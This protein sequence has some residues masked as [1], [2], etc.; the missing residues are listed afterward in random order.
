MSKEQIEGLFFLIHCRPL[1]PDPKTLPTSPRQSDILFWSR[2]FHS[3]LKFLWKNL[4]LVKRTRMVYW[5]WRL[6]VYTKCNAESE[7]FT[8]ISEVAMVD[9]QRKWR[10]KERGIIST[11]ES[12]HE[13]H[14]SKHTRA[15]IYMYFGTRQ[16][17]EFGRSVFENARVCFRLWEFRQD[18]PDSRYLCVAQFG[19][20]LKNFQ[21]RIFF[22]AFLTWIKPIF[23]RDMRSSEVQCN[24]GTAR[25]RL[26]C[27]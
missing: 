24:G 25:T 10:W 18:L 23:Y 27:C 14:Q 5:P 9:G 17:A 8:K 7:F 1:Q 22:C 15:P 3:R 12:V 26:P 20:R 16:N 4:G 11:E 13:T 2:F 21:V 6:E 19:L